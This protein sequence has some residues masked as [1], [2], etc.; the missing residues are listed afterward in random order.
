MYLIVYFNPYLHQ[1][2]LNLC[3]NG[4]H[5]MEATG[6]TLTIS[7]DSV[8]FGQPVMRGGDEIKAGIYVRL[9]VR[10]TGEGIGPQHLAR[11]FD[12]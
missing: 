5:A 1:I 3:T 10:D 9:T 2:L 4:F 12:P 7:L 11:I 6:G 8:T